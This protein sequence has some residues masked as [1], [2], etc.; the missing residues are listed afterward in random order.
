MDLHQSKLN[1]IFFVA[2]I[3]VDDIGRQLDD[4]EDFGKLAQL[5][6][7]ISAGY[8]SQIYTLNKYT[9]DIEV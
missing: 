4:S 9:F 7:C 8:T 5:R 3:D 1:F 6:R 2:F